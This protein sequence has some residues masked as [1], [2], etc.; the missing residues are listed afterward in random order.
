LRPLNPIKNAAIID[1]F[2]RPLTADERPLYLHE[3]RLGRA[4]AAKQAHDQAERKQRDHATQHTCRIC[5][6]V[7]ESTRDRALPRAAL[8]LAARGSASRYKA[9]EPCE[10]LLTIRLAAWA[11]VP[12][13]EAG[14]RLRGELVDD[15]LRTLAGDPT[16]PRALRL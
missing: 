7:D 12:V 8:A 13:E 10:A 1:A 15:W 5:Q 4:A 6:R 11:D 2:D 3:L 9:C 16:T 14:G